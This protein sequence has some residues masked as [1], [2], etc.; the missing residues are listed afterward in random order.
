MTDALARWNAMDREEAA[1]EILPCCGSRAWADDLASARPITSV[2]ELLEASQRLWLGLQASDWME[3]FRTHPRIG[4]SSDAAV[5]SAKARKWSSEEQRKVTEGDDEVKVALAEA[6][7]SYE[8][9]F[10]RTFIVCATGKSPQEILQILRRRLQNDDAVEMRE[11]ADQQLQI[12][13]IRLRRW[14]EE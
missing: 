4:N 1:R 2:A 6:N 10:G 13:E 3:A 5:A 12:T 11:A 14:L 8:Q 7:R 9:R